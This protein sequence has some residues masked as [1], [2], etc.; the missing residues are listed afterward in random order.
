MK[1]LYS[2]L[3]FDQAIID[4]KAWGHILESGIGSYIVSEAFAKRFEVPKAAFIVGDGGIK[5]EDFL[6]MDLRKLF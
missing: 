5:P 6:S 3:S 1:T 2:S 4:R